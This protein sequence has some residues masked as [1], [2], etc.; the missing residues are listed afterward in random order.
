V[1]HS[2]LGVGEQ[3]EGDVGAVGGRAIASPFTSRSVLPSTGG[4]GHVYAHGMG[5]PSSL[6]AHLSERLDY[7]RL[8]W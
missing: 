7:T 1:Q 5:N 4:A 6:T 3:V 8:V 2:P